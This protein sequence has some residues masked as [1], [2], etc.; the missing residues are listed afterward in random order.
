MNDM[1]ELENILDD[2]LAQIEDG[3]AGLDDCLKQYPRQAVELRPML[4]AALDLGRGRELAPSRSYKTR[5]RARLVD[6]WQAHPKR[7]TA[8]SPGVM[9]LSGA[10]AVVLALVMLA[11]TAYAQGALPGES[12][13]G[14]KIASEKAWRA[15]APDPVAVDIS[16]ANRR[17]DEL[18]LVTQHRGQDNPSEQQAQAEALAQY[19]AILQQ[20]QSDTDPQDMGQI[21]QVLQAHQQQFQQAGIDVPQLDA[22]L[23]GKGNNGPSGGGSG[24]GGG[25]GGG[26]GGGG[27]GGGSG[28]GGGK[29]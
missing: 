11:G 13:Y 15:V 26:S 4:E 14:W 29:P 12:F 8:F 9:R 28:G 21:M 18:A 19:H 20:L 10:L 3:R 16:I 1:N 25:G 24:S 6:Y 7:K 22:I 5:A 23:H 17:A 27:G 2:C